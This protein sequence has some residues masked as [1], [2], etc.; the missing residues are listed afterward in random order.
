[1][2]RART[3]DCVEEGVPRSVAVK[4]KQN[5]GW[6]A[7]HRS[8]QRSTAA[9]EGRFSVSHHLS[10]SGQPWPLQV[11]A[12]LR[13]RAPTI[14]S[15]TGK[16]RKQRLPFLNKNLRRKRGSAIAKKLACGHICSV[17]YKGRFEVDYFLSL[18]GRNKRSTAANACAMS[19]RGRSSGKKGG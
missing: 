6:V 9:C 11:A 5:C 8:S 17:E 16:Q 14:I 18:H 1:M 10:L 15:T 2:N 13:Q 19:N 12:S 4:D 3:R 7:D